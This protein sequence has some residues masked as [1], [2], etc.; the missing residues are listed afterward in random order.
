MQ[1]QQSLHHGVQ[2][3]KTVLIEASELL[4]TISH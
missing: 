1:Q 3:P 4:S 2:Q